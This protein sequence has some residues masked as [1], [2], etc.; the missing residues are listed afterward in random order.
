MIKVNFC[1]GTTL[2]FNLDKANDLHQFDEW[3]LVQDFQKKITGIGIFHD[4]RYYTLPL[5]KRFKH[6]QFYAEN[7]FKFKH[8]SKN[9]IA[10]KVICH[11]DNVKLSLTVYTLDKKNIPIISRIDLVNIGRQVFTGQVGRMKDG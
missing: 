2:E 7:V 6:V 10:E 1:D 8:G 5:P 3:S 11:A 9:K 4:K